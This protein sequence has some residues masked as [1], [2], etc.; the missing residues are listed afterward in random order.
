M[1]VTDGQPVD[2]ANTNPAFLD[3]NGDDT[4]LGRISLNDTVGNPTESGPAINNIQREL[5]SIASFVGK[6]I[7]VAKDILPTWLFA[8][9]GT[10]T[11]NVF[12]RADAL[13]AKFNVSTGHAHTGAAG[14]G[15]PISAPNLANVPLRGYFQEGTGLTAVT[16]GS[17]VVTTQMSGKTPSTGS[18]VLGVVTNAPYN[19]VIIRDTDG[20][21]FVD[22]SG[23]EVYARLTES[24][25]VWT[26][27]FFVDLAG[28]ET[29][30]SFGSSVDMKWFY[31][32][33][34]NPM[35]NPPVYDPGAFIPSD[36]AT[37]DVVDA[38][39][40]QRGLV[41]TG[42]QSFAG[43]KTFDDDVNFTG[44]V[45]PGAIGDNEIAFKDQ[46]TQALRGLALVK[47]SLVSA[48]G[49]AVPTALG[50]G[51][52][53][54]M[55][56]ADSAEPTGLKWTTPAAGANQTLSNLT[57]PTAINQDLRADAD[58]TRS[59][60]SG[61]IAWLAARVV[62]FL[63]KGNVV[64]FVGDVT[65]TSPTITA[66][67][68]TSALNEFQS[69]VGT[70]IPQGSYIISKT[71]NSVTLNQAATATTVSAT[72]QAAFMLN[73]LTDGQTGSDSSGSWFGRTGAAVNGKSGAAMLKTGDVSGSGDSG[74]I[75]LVTGSVT[76]GIRGLIK[77]LARYFVMPTRTADPSDFSAGGLYW[78]TAL[79]KFRQSDG[80]QWKDLSG[81]GSG[82]GVNYISNPGF[83][84]GNVNGWNGYDDGASSR[85]V[86][87]TG[88]TAT[89]LTMTASSTTPLRD[90]YSA[91]I[92]KDAVNRQG[93]GYAIDFSIAREDRFSMQSIEVPALV[94]SGTYNPGTDS[95]D[96]DL[97]A[98]IYDVT[99]SRLI[100]PSGF[101]VMANSTFPTRNRMTF[102][103][104]DSTSYRLILHVATTSASA[105]TVQV[106]DL[107]VGPQVLGQGNGSQYLGALPTSSTW[108]T[109]ASHVGK[110]W[111]TSDGFLEADVTISLTGAPT[112]ASLILNTPLNLS[113]DQDRQ[114]TIGSSAIVGGG[115]VLDSGSTL[116]RLAAKYE[117][118]TS[119]RL[120][121]APDT[122]SGF[123]RDMVNSIDNTVPMTFANADAI[124]VRYRVPIVGWSG[125]TV[126]SSA[127]SLPVIAAKY[128]LTS[129]ET[130][131]ANADH[132][133]TNF[134][135]R[136]Y[137]KSGAVSGSTFTAQEYGLYRFRLRATTTSIA[138]T[139]TDVITAFLAKNG[140][141][142]FEKIVN[143]KVMASFTDR[144]FL[145]GEGTLELNARDTVQ[146][147]IRNQNSG[148]VPVIDSAG[149]NYW[150]IEKLPSRQ[151]IAASEVI[152]FSGRNGSGTTIGNSLTT[153]PFATKDVDT[154]NSY[155]ISNGVYTI[156]A[157]GLY[158][159]SATIGWTSASWTAGSIL[160]LRILIDGSSARILQQTISRTATQEVT[161]MVISH[162][163]QLNTGQTVSFAGF[164]NETAAGRTLAGSSLY[165]FAS[166]KRLGGVG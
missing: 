115:I 136:V 87:G 156:Q 165:N 74:D 80:T 120:M 24:V 144:L 151:Q 27:T 13:T 14:Q 43:E 71:A 150:E 94:T 131:A 79:N 67:A 126:M 154:H 84:D 34:F 65:N 46:P 39:S 86:N 25:G 158:E 70:G 1:G 118:A 114:S 22:G 42:V 7:N 164:Q 101:R 89:G 47:G 20:Q 31:Q 12:Q 148:A 137:D 130:T 44:D 10:P 40:T 9:A 145:A 91:L 8:D 5:N 162:L 54:Q 51:T 38:S 129:N 49:S 53:G 2:A 57:S 141:T 133:M 108:V 102:Q 83:E 81:S 109:N 33:L 35:V 32:E 163:I 29:A 11:D 106:D 113:I 121:V 36:A 96:S 116:Y 134:T 111:R 75:Q 103:A 152:A 59:L 77:A 4:A 55:L 16:G 88:G 18:S 125:S 85:P 76:S 95:T 90:T 28:V 135:T 124:T 123:I 19:R 64:S 30:Y 17:K 41:S 161:G 62:Q 72:L 119:I 63:T 157:P 160:D 143:E 99:N 98:Y 66:I 100:E 110:Y 97:I 105:W 159:I 48:D 60:G 3:A 23:N 153:I 104:T 26:L 142:Q 92:A 6:A 155:N 146:L 122:G 112:A 52:N 140:A 50:V 61:A 93:K 58:Q 132:I 147:N 45:K 73:T 117:S 56:T 138:W 82:G 21:E 166:I 15:A 127:A 149:F 128:S 107:L 69:V 78:N 37:A 139:T 68:D